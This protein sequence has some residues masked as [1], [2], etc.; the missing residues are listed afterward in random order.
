LH[1]CGYKDKTEEDEQLMRLKED[2]KIK[3]FHVEQ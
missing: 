1:Y 3:L 2:E